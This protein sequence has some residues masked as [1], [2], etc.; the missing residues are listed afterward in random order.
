M[1]FWTKLDNYI[2]KKFLTTFVFA[3]LILA[4][5]SCV[6]DYTQKVEDFVS[7][8]APTSTVLLYFLTFAP[9]IVALLYPLFIFIATI[10]F[11]SKLAY[12]TE[13]IAILAS[14]V[15]FR[16]FLR[17][18][19]VGSILLGL[20][21]FFAN[22]WLIPSST[23]VMNEI[24]KKYYYSE[25]I[26]SKGNIHIKVA[27][28]EYIFVENFTYT[29]NVGTRFTDEIIVGTDLKQKIFAER[30]KYDS[31]TNEWILNDVVVR[32]NDGLKETLTKVPELKRKFPFTPDDL[33]ADDRFKEELTSPELLRTIEKEKMKGTDNITFFQ[34]EYYK[35]TAQPIA[36][37]ILVIIGVC[38]SSKKVRGGSGL[39]LALGIGISAI[40]IMMMQFSNTFSTNSGLDPIIAVWIPNIIFGIVAFFLYRKELK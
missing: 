14:G 36:G 38:I 33:D 3:I 27:P 11:T 12:K 17:P 5:I 19:V 13:I 34:L 25:K 18:Y 31:T 2:L 24:K 9:N 23:K 8:N 7:K 39:H 35:R 10:F 37:F 6:I 15:S 40:Y 16:R 29:N 32:K 30:I 28:N 4:V 26:A 22:H 21:S 1:R 20:C